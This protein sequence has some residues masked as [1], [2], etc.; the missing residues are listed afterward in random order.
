MTIEQFHLSEVT[1]KHLKNVAYGH[2]VFQANTFDGYHHVVGIYGPNGS[3]K[4]TV[5]EALHLISELWKGKALTQATLDILPFDQ[6]ATVAVVFQL[7]ET[8]N[9]HYEVTIERTLDQPAFATVLH[10][11]LTTQAVHEV[12]ATSQVVFDWQSSHLAE[13]TQTNQ[14]QLT[15][16]FILNEDHSTLQAEWVHR[17]KDEIAPRIIYISKQAMDESRIWL[18]DRQQHSSD[19][20]NWIDYESQHVLSDEAIDQLNKRL[21]PLNQVLQALLPDL[22]VVATSTEQNQLEIWAVRSDRRLL[23]TYESTGTK[24]IIQLISALIN[25]YHDE[26]AIVLIDE[27]DS[28]IYEYLLGELLEVMQRGA[29]GQLIFTSHNLRPLEILEPHQIY[30]ATF[31]QSNRYVQPTFDQEETNLR[32]AYLRLLQVDQVQQKGH[33]INPFTIQRALRTAKRWLSTMDERGESH[34]E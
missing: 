31:T 33:Q 4:T 21:I 15:S 27:L 16:P 30:F 2:V 29:R 5:L 22:A 11:K 17:L 25:V 26:A 20:L 7:N 28:G 19:A 24:K 23:L 6:P 10:E 14:E 13:I 12:D 9:V 1:V 8:I 18:P 34:E 3:G 32:D